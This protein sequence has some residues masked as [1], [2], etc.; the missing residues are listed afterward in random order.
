MMRAIIAGVLLLSA[1]PATGQSCLG[2]PMPNGALALDANASFG[3]GST[4]FG[5]GIGRS[6]PA[7]WHVGVAIDDIE[8]LDENA[9]GIGGTAG[10]KLSTQSAAEICP[11]ISLGY[12][13]YGESAGGLEL[14]LR[15][16][17]FAPAIGIGYDIGLATPNTV[18][19][20]FAI[21]TLVRTNTTAEL[22]DGVDT[23]RE[24]ESD[25]FV[26]VTLGG[27]YGFRAGYVSGS[28]G[29]SSAD[30]SDPVFSLGVGLIVSGATRAQE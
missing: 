9:Y 19:A 4:G 18:L 24:E 30:G 10:A 7:I 1:V 5:F 11:V 25:T 29:L 23:L 14:D 16:L 22:T 2:A 28:V 27:A 17:S 20:L 8:D 3:E 6:G 13:W 15:Q 26:A 21:P 12:W